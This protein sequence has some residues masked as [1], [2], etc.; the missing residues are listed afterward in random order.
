MAGWLGSFASVLKAKMF[1]M[2][3]FM[4]SLAK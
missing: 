3:K 4:A 2:K 1:G